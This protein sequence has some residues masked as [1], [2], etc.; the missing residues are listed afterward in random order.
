M[1]A[2]SP[3]PSKP[4][5]FYIYKPSFCPQLSESGLLYCCCCQPL[6]G[7]ISGLFCLPSPPLPSPPLPSPRL[8]SP[9]LP[10]PPLPFPHNE[11]LREVD[12]DV[13]KVLHQKDQTEEERDHTHSDGKVTSVVVTIVNKTRTKGLSLVCDTAKYNDGSDLRGEKP[14]E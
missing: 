13:E 7:S 14:E 5:S 3:P 11:I 8:A 2:G 10:S 12:E 6:L 4:P 9:P 1:A